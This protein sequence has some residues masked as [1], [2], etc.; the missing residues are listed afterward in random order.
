MRGVWTRRSLSGWLR[1]LAACA[2]G[3]PVIVSVHIPLVTGFLR[4]CRR[5]R[6]LRRITG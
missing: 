6:C 4:T 2:A 3:T 5:C 1:D